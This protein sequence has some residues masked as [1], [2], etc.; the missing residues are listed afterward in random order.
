MRTLVEET[1]SPGYYNI[2][3]DGKNDVGEQVTSGVYLYKII[4]TTENGG[5]QFISVKK[6]SFVQ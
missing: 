2:L 5:K 3:W 1:Q 4:A 6:M